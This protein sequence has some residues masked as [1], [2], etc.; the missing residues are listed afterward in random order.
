MTIRRRD[1]LTVSSAGL[2]AAAG[3]RPGRTAE[4]TETKPAALRIAHITDV[5]IT[6]DREAPEGVASMLAHIFGDEGWRPELILNTGDSVMGVDG[7]TSGAAAEAQIATWKRAFADCPVPIRSCLGNHDVWNGDAPTAAVPATKKGFAL[8][9]EALGMPDPYYSFDHGGWHFISLNS[10]CNWPSYATLSDEHFAWLV[11]DLEATSLPTV[12][13]SHVPILSVTSQVYGDDIRKGND[14]IVPGT[15]HH[16]DC[17]AITEVF[18]RHPQV[19]LCLSGHMHTADHCVYREVAYVCGGAASGAW[20]NGSEYGFP[21]CYGRL[22][23]F[24]DG[25]FRYDLIDY[26]WKARA[27]RGKQLDLS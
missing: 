19:K 10:V 25:S 24:G 4:G 23:L 21:P 13:I 12:V 26:G 6:P 15:W 22:D 2:F 3:G 16:A 27:W 9:T 1:V 14:N 11:A 17:W 20:W 8:M 5:H 18:R 7:R